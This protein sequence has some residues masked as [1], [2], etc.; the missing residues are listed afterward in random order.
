[1]TRSQE[2]ERHE[3]KLR[4]LEERWDVMWRKLFSRL[5]GSQFPANAMPLNHDIVIGKG[6]M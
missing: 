6:L 1:M 4:S 5:K 2:G 3:K